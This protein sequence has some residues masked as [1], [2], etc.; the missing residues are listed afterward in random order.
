M[1]QDER[2]QSQYDQMMAFMKTNHRISHGDRYLSHGSR[3]TQAP[4]P[5][6]TLDL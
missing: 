4:V 6:T 1:T 3:Q 2:W 5:V